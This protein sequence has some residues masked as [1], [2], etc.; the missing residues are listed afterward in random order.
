MYHSLGFKVII[1]LLFGSSFRNDGLN[2]HHF[3][4][5]IKR[6]LK[7]AQFMWHNFVFYFNMGLVK[8]AIIWVIAFLI[9]LRD[10]H[11]YVKSL[12][13]PINVHQIFN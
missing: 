11:I 2:G 9:R 1:I 6:F 7:S 12:I 8:Y 10:L 4:L 13:V 3:Y 5:L